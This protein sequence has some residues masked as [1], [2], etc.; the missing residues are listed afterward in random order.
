MVTW[1]DPHGG[2]DS[3]AVSADLSSGAV[4]S[5]AKKQRKL[6][7]RIHQHMSEGTGNPSENE[8]EAFKGLN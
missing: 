8:V 1:G 2:G 6:I 5:A 4:T 3:S 7:F